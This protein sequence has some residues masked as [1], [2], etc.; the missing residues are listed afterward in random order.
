MGTM[1]MGKVES[2][3]VKKGDSLLLM[4]NKTTV[5]VAGI[6]TEQSEEMEQAFCGDNIR[7]RIRGTT[8]EDVQPGYVL[9]SVQRPV[10]AVTAF[11]ADLSFIETKSIVC[12]GYTAVLHVHTLAEEITISAL[13]HYLDKKTKR[14]S[15][16][17]PQF[18]KAGMVVTALIETTAPICI[19]TFKDFK[20]LGRFTL[21]DEGRTVAIGKVTKLVEK[22]DDMP[23]VAALNV[24]AGGA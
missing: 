12:S 23:D 17:P 11:K 4:P 15:K 8:D 9:S 13:L 2:G 5:E 6:Y 1:V 22:S 20:Q 10:K 18:A 19:E 21:R 14:K 24:A 16:K 7:M 3:R